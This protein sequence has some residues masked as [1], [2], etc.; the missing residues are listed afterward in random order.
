M[1]ELRFGDNLGQWLIGGALAFIGWVMKTFTGSHLETMK[2]IEERLADM[3][4]DIRSLK[5]HATRTDKRL[6]RIEDDE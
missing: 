6:D 2:R 3:Q 5:D 4:A 1:D